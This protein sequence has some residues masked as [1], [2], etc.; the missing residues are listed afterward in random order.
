MLAV[1]VCVRVCKVSCLILCKHE[2]K[3]LFEDVTL[4]TIDS[5][6]VVMADGVLSPFSPRDPRDVEMN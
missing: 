4:K 5:Q 6:G 3:L 2:I 1:Y